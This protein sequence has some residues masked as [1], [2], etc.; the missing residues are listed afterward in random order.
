[1]P[2]PPPPSRGLVLPNTASGQAFL[3]SSRTLPSDRSLRREGTTGV[4]GR[5]RQEGLP[6]GWGRALSGGRAI[7]K[8]ESEDE[9]L[10]ENP[11]RTAAD[12]DDTPR[13]CPASRGAGSFLEPPQTPPL[14]F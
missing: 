7:T 9:H 12:T 5:E 1:M 3:P 10:R 6:C 11:V 13:G 4:A 2:N 8:V 14:T